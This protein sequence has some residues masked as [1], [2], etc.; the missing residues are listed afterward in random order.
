MTRTLSPIA[1]SFSVLAGPLAWFFQFMLVYIVA[2]FG[3]RANFSNAV[4]FEPNGIRLFTFITT[5]VALVPVALGGF[6]ALRQAQ[7]L[8]PHRENDTEHEARERFLVTLGMAFSI[9][10]MLSIIATALPAFFVAV[11]DRAL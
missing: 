10:F 1:V 2:E 8:N 3:C 6:W 5:L 11:C 4:Y 7:Q 9:I